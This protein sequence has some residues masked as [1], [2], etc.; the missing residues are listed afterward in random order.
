MPY[1]SAILS[2]IEELKD[3]QTGSP[4][5]SIR[6]HIKE[7]DTSFAAAIANDDDDTTW[8][9]T[10]FQSTLKSLITK[11]VLTNVNGSNYKFSD[12]YLSRRAEGL[13]ARAESMEERQRALLVAARDLHPREE[14]PKELP[15]KKTV[16]AKV[17]INEAKIIT[18]VSP[19]GNIMKDG[20]EMETE[21]DDDGILMKD[22]D[23]NKN[24]LKKKHVKI[25]PRKVGA[26]KKMISDPMNT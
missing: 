26:K 12:D 11:N 22:N 6:R 7:H 16:H 18:V 4:A 21:D 15:K 20:D 3:H 25:I 13:R 2:A 1:R 19:E 24:K 5:S 9:E 14:P 10:L 8:N 17:K 23:G